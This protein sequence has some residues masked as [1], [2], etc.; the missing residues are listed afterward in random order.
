L[1]YFV[2]FITSWSCGFVLAG[3]NTAGVIV[4]KS[5]GL[6]KLDTTLITTSG[7]L[8]L[9][10]GS[11]FADKFLQFGRT[12]T[13]YLANLL[14]I[15]SVPSQMWLSV[16]GFMIGRFLLGFGSGLC[17]VSCSVFCAETVPA[18]KLGFIGTAVNTGIIFALLVSDF[19]QGSTLPKTTDDAG[20][21]ACETCWRP[22]FY[23]PG[24]IAGISIISW[25]ILIRFDSLYYC[26]DKYQEENGLKQFRRVYAFQEGSNEEYQAWEETKAA[27]KYFLQTKTTEPSIAAIFQDRK[28]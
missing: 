5:R 11:L 23:W 19:I 21:A 24:I 22:G 2:C 28:Y 7:V 15:V 27:R 16:A 18:D 6:H 3:Y 17:L 13:I 12:K 26:I 1:I 14:I 4:E 10:L 8:G 9:T 20:I 25:L